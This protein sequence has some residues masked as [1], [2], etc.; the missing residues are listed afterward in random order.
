MNLSILSTNDLLTQLRNLETA[1]RWARDLE[2]L[3]LYSDWKA[4]RDE[5]NARPTCEVLQ[6]L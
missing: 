1:G 2:A 6:T 5:L 3:R 4:V